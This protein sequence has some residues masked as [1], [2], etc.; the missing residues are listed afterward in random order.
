MNKK[1]FI[2]VPADTPH[3]PIKGAYALANSL[4]GVGRDVTIVSVKTGKGAKANLDAAVKKICLADYASGYFNKLTLYRSMLSKA[5][6]R[7]EVASISMCFSAD[8]INLACKRQSITC[9]SVRANLIENYRMDYGLLGIILAVT[10]LSAL[11]F[12]D[13]VVVMNQSMA[14]QVEKYIGKYPNVIGNFIDEKTLE[15]IPIVRLFDNNM[16]F[17]FVGSLSKRKRPWMVIKA[18][19]SLLSKG[20]VVQLDI[21]GDGPLRSKMEDKIVRYKLS[22]FVRLYGFQEKP[23]EFLKNADVMVL[24][25]LSEGASRSVMEALY[26]GIPC[27][28]ADMD[29]NSE[30]VIDGYNGAL[31]N[32]PDELENAMLR[33]VQI[34][35]NFQN[36]RP[37]LLPENNRQTYAVSIFIRMLENSLIL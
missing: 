8:A 26:L 32:T 12:F 1:Y 33:A 10:H 4:V 9:S 30:L 7:D 36:S 37:I 29:G 31:F 34:S 24:P 20:L 13:K 23:Y 3:G 22:T 27:V 11:R 5:G 14:R 16:R 15:H 21:L 25:S 18:I 2:I 35:R 28:M 19:K 6:T 17:I